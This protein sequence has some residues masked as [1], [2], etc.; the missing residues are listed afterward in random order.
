MEDGKEE[1]LPKIKKL[2]PIEGSEILTLSNAVAVFVTSPKR[3]RVC[4][5]SF[6]NGITEIALLEGKVPLVRKLKLGAFVLIVGLVLGTCEG[7]LEGG[8]LV[9]IK[10]GSAEGVKVGILVGR[11]EGKAVEKVGETVGMLE[12]LNIG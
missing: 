10:E 9:P 3:K 8:K 12:G 2:E 6:V 7:V 11:V 1:V 4:R 5:N